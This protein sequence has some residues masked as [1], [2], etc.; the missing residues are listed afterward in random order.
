MGAYLLQS[1]GPH[2]ISRRAGPFDLLL[3]LHSYQTAQ[4]HHF[5]NAVL[6]GQSRQSTASSVQTTYFS[7][8][9]SLLQHQSALYRDLAKGRCNDWYHTEWIGLEISA[10]FHKIHHAVR[11]TGRRV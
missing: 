6:S 10:A 2:F 8:L 3:R 4:S 7:N 1:P 9:P 5:G 11:L